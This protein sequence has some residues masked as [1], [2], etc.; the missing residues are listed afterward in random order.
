MGFVIVLHDTSSSNRLM[1]FIRTALAYRDKIDLI[2]LSRMTGGAA[3]YGVPDACKLLYKEGVNLLVLQDLDDVLE[4]FPNGKVYQFTMKQSKPLSTIKNEN[5]HSGALLLF[6]GS[7]T[8]FAENE[9]LTNAEKIYP[10]GAMKE[11]PPEAC[12]AS[13]MF[14]VSVSKDNV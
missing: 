8:G 12:L 1:S 14:F 5:I 3:Q 4:L 9:L 11:L 13:F 10:D 7:E 2:V 6:S